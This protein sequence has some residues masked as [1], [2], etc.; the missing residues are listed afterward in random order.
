MI[1]I[2]L[3]DNQDIKCFSGLLYTKDELPNYSI[4]L[5]DSND[6][7]YEFL[8]TN[9]YVNSSLPLKES[10]E[11]GLENISKKTG[12]YFL[13][14]GADSTS[15]MGAYEVFK[16]SNAKY[17]FKKQLLSQEDYKVKS[18]LNKWFFGN[19]S[20]LDKGYDIPNDVY[21]KIKLTGYNV[22]HNWP[23]LQKMHQGN[24]VRDIDVCAVYQGILDNGNMDHEVRSDILYTNHRKGAWDELSKIENK[25]NIIK[26]KSTSEQFIEI[27]RRS[28][29]GLSPFGMGELC[30]RDLEL[31]Q[32]GCLLIKPDMSKV[33][34]EPDF[35]KPMETYVPVKPDWSDLNE[36]IEKILGNYNKYLYIIE[37]ARKQVTQLYSYDNVCMYWYNFFANM[38]GIQ[39]ES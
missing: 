37:N 5:T 7:D 32:W 39:N 16:Q 29:I 13:F 11:W 27:M 1:K 6:Y 15:I 38:N 19:G 2:K 24:D 30:Y 28:K 10:I 21:S 8:G 36:V 23:H 34:T 35:F 20:V 25:Y 33:I 4:Q 3:S 12:D 31:I 18:I 26:G 22:A 9:E 17:L 14:H